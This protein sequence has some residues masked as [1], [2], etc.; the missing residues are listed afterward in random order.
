MPV[1]NDFSSFSVF[2]HPPKIPFPLGFFEDFFSIKQDTFLIPKLLITFLKELV[3]GQGSFSAE[4]TGLL[5]FYTWNGILLDMYDPDNQLL[6]SVFLVISGPL[7][8]YFT[9]LISL[10]SSTKHIDTVWYINAVR[11]F[12][13]IFNLLKRSVT[14]SVSEKKILKAY[15]Y[16]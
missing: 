5:R 1:F 13:L 15:Q 12:G 10:Q 8:E 4:C 14:I 7:Q 16:K 11:I 3:V 2:F 6:N 9:S